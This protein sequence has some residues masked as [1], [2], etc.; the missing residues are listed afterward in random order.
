VEDIGR[1]SVTPSTIP[2]TNASVYVID[3]LESVF[4]PDTSLASITEVFPNKEK[5]EGKR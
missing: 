4:W 5:C 3:E 2:Y 1:N